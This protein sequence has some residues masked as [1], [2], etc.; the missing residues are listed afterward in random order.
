MNV[1][2]VN[3]EGVQNIRTTVY[4]HFSRHFKSLG[5]AR[6]GVE[7]LS[8]RKLSFGEAENLTKP[9]SLEEVRRAVWECDSYKSPRPVDINFGFI[10]EFWDML[11]DDFMRF[12]VEFH[13]NGKL[14]KGVNSTFIALILK[15]N[16]LQRLNDLWPISLVG[17]IYI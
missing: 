15:V 10:K 2:G 14:T 9:F 8:F 7:N 1:N 16:S 4:D 13:R 6:P 17:C 3:I 5:T 12:I 11:K